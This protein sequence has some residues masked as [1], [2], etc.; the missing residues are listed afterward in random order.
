MI[1]NEVFQRCDGCHDR[2]P[3][4]GL[5]LRVGE[6]FDNLVNQ[7]SNRKDGAVLVIPF[8]PDNSYL[9]QKMV[10]AEGILGSS[11]NYGGPTFAQ[12][13]REWIAAGALNN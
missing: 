5:D 7:P 1:Q 13:V 2:T 11:M 9:W 4:G 3:A 12:Q 8:D 10:G 6:S